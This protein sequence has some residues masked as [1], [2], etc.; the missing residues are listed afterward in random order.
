MAESKIVNYDGYAFKPGAVANDATV[1]ARF[2]A[3]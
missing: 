1:M 2:H 3:R